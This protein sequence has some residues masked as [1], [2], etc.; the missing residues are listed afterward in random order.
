MRVNDTGMI[1]SGV[2]RNRRSNDGNIL[3]V[4]NAKNGGGG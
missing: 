1:I 2:N 3:A 4:D